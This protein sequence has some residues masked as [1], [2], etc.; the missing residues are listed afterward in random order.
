MGKLRQRVREK[1][2]AMSTSQ[3]IELIVDYKVWAA[4]GEAS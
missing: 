3:L 1:L 4:S 2:N